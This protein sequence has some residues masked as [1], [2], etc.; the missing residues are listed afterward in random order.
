M[1]GVARN[2]EGGRE[3]ELGKGDGREEGGEVGRWARP[4]WLKILMSPEPGDPGGGRWR[5]GF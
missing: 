1:V 2:R 3:G 4:P 5:N